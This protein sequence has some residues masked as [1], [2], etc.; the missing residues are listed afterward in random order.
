MMIVDTPA[1]KFGVTFKHRPFHKPT[2]DRDLCKKF[3]NGRTDCDIYLFKGVSPDANLFVSGVGLCKFPDAFC[4]A[5]GRKRSLTSALG[6]RNDAGQGLFSKHTRQLIWDAYWAMVVPEEETI[7]EAIAAKLL[8]IDAL[9]AQLAS[10]DPPPQSDI[11]MAG[12]DIGG[13]GP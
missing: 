1:G 4:K 5:L 10:V 11:C 6:K 13:N 3:L 12:L 2:F 7:E 9:R 8:E